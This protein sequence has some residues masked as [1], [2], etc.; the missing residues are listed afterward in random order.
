MKRYFI[1]IAL[2]IA[3]L[4]VCL[5]GPAMAGGI[6]G[7]VKVKGLRS[8]ANILVYLTKAPPAFVDLSKTKFAMD[9]QN[10]TFIPHILPIPVGAT[11]QFPNNDKVDHNVFSLSR[12]KPFNLGSYKP[13]EVKTVLFDKPGIVEVRCDVHAEM[14][15]Y[16][17]VMKNPYFA[18][19]DAKGRF[20]MPDA[21]YMKEYGFSGLTDIPPGKYFIKTR[22]EK[23][24]TI[25]QAVVVP[26]AGTISIQLELSRGTPGVLYK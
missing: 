18:V 7:T 10:L 13:G 20:E 9:Q 6:S 5:P 22:H 12:T 17:M 3:L 14:A 23:L 2:L 16:I 19:T 26:N 11:I 8:P 21:N 4:A 25:K 1:T 15:A 24:K